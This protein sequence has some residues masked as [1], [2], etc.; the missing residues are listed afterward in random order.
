MEQR[1]NRARIIASFYF[2]LLGLI[3]FLATAL[4]N[5]EFNLRDSIVLLVVIAPALIN[6]KSVYLI[7][8]VLGAL[9]SLYI[10]I[11][12]LI[13]NIQAYPTTNQFSFL[14]G[15]VLAISAFIASSLYI[16]SGLDH[17]KLE[18]VA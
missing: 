11:A 14:M 8:G 17:S 13:L 16:Y 2:I 4:S 3:N 12:C 7:F 1:I 6:N 10:G 18:P 9:I 5:Y 15:Y